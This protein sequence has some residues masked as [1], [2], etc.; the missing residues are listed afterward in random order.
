MTPS[1]PLVAQIS[2]RSPEILA[3]SEEI[4]VGTRSTASLEY[5]SQR[6]RTR[7]NAPL[8]VGLWLVRAAPH[9]AQTGLEAR[10]LIAR[11]EG[12]G[13]NAHPTPPGLKGRN[14]PPNPAQQRSGSSRRCR[15]FGFP[16]LL[17]RLHRASAVQLAIGPWKNA[18]ASWTAPALWRSSSP[19][20]N[21]SQRPLTGLP[22]LLS[23]LGS[24]EESAEER[25]RCVD[26][27]PSTLNYQAPKPGLRFGLAPYIVGRSSEQLE[28]VGG[29]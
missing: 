14:S 3:T 7:W 6:M 26:P 2:T 23:G 9:L 27:R 28:G 15:N 8:P 12:P 1:S 22:L 18:T 25:R 29:W 20:P 13:E 24:D 10:H 17:L 11:P 4:L 21:T 16:V 5:L 19:A